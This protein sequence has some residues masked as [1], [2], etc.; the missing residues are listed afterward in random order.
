MRSELATIDSKPTLISAV[1]N[2][3]NALQWQCGTSENYKS[4]KSRS[5]VVFP[6]TPQARSYSQIIFKYHKVL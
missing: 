6:D 3:A 1:A 4:D 2:D 5:R